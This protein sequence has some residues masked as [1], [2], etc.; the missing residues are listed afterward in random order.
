MEDTDTVE[1]EPVDLLLYAKRYQ[2]ADGSWVSEEPQKNYL[3]MQSI[4]I[5]AKAEGKPISGRDIVEK[6]LKKKLKYGP[7]RTQDQQRS[8]NSKQN[9]RQQGLKRKEKPRSLL[10]RYKSRGAAEKPG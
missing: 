7:K 10:R 4:W 3:E 5:E 1:E 8:F 2:R 6:V 9:W